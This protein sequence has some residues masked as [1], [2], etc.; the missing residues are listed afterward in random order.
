MKK[1]ISILL[2]AIVYMGM[3]P[4]EVTANAESKGNIFDNPS[5]LTYS[6]WY[7][8][9]EQQGNNNG[10]NLFTVFDDN[11]IYGPNLSSG[12]GDVLKK[13]NGGS[14]RYNVG[15]TTRYYV[16][17][18][19]LIGPYVYYWGQVN[20]N[21]FEI[22][23]MLTSGSNVNTIIPDVHEV[24]FTDEFI[25][26]TKGS[27]D[28]LYR[29]DL[30]GNNSELILDCEVFYPF[31]YGDVILYQKDADNESLHLYNME[32]NTDTKLNSYK[33]HYPIYDGEYIYYL[34]EQNAKDDSL[35]FWKMRPDGTENTQIKVPF[36]AC[37]MII[38]EDYIY[39]TNY[40]DGLRIYRCKKDG[41][42]VMQITQEDM[43]RYMQWLGDKLIYWTQ[44]SNG[45][46]IYWCNE[47]GQ[48]KTEW[49]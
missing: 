21:Q 46:H 20:N 15:K 11:W 27:D 12:V 1:I 36:E 26:Y 29:C 31:A 16:G 42:D 4:L 37:S 48:Q 25:Y 38:H 6:E 32:T 8:L 24:C 41:S 7:E 19:A 34:S 49:K 35:T 9:I 17:V 5:I 28:K 44:G 18:K 39:F 2:L 13:A 33:S 43:V 3:L 45:S 10:G 47:V 14:E 30:D 22:V 40:Q 23:K